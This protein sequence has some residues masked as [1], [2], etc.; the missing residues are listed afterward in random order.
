MATTK[1][2]RPKPAKERISI[3]LDQDVVKF[4]K[5]RAARSG[6]PPYQTQINAE[7]RAVMEGGGGAYASLLND[8]KFIAAVAERVLKL[9]GRGRR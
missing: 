6:A 3:L 4:F 5:K 7:L 9:R 8:E 2:A 1:K